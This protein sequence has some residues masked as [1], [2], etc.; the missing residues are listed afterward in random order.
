MVFTR[1]CQYAV[2]AMAHFACF[3]EGHLCRVQEIA[4]SQNLPAPFLATVLQNLARAGLMKSFKGPK[5]GF[6]LGRPANQITL[7]DIL[8]SF[9][10]LKG[11]SRCAIGQ[12]DCPG[13]R[14]CPLHD[15]WEPV[16]QSVI[17]YLQGMTVA[18]MAAA[19]PL[20]NELK[21]L[22]RL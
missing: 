7:H 15:R 20:K 6:C 1:S 11:L 21:N 18:D 17:D 2:L 4:E 13:D 8:E 10:S 12:D 14:L 3:K 16:R 22:L 9:G 19:V 5:G